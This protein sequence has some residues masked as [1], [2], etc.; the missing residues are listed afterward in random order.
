MAETKRRSMT[1]LEIMDLEDESVEQF[2]ASKL[3]HLPQK[4]LLD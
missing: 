1:T 4:E 3:E 2:G